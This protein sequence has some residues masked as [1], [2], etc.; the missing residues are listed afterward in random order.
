M[1]QK[2]KCTVTHRPH[3]VGDSLMAT[4]HGYC[5]YKHELIHSKVS[6]MMTFNC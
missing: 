2:H 1:K 3:T 5:N 4:Y 6:A